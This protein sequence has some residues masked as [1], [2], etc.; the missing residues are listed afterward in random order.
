MA[1]SLSQPAGDVTASDQEL[2]GAARDGDRAAFGEL[3]QRYARMVQGVLLAA[4]APD[5]ADDL[6]QDVFLKAMMQLRQLRSDTHFGGWI[7]AIARNRAVD[8]YRRTRETRETT[9]ADEVKNAAP[10]REAS[11]ARAEAEV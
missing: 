8:Y 7:A 2:V 3:Y 10:G 9:E 11:D 4:A 1:V 5:V 6:L